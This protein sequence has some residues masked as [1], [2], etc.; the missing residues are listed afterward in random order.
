MSIP[1]SDQ[2][3]CVRREIAM[4]LRVYPRMVETKAMTQAWAD[5]QIEHMQS[6]LKTLETLL[7]QEAQPLE[8]F[9]ESGKQE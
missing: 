1:L 6:V 8:L 9:E 4:R 3:S 5:Y 7:E 2:I